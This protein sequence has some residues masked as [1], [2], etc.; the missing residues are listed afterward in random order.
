MKKKLA[1]LSLLIAFMMGLVACAPGEMLNTIIWG[2]T[3]GTTYQPVRTDSTTHAMVS[4]AYP[5]Y[6]VHGG[7]YFYVKG[8]GDGTIVFLWVCPDTARAPHANWTLSAEGEFE[9]MMY[10]GVVTSNDGAPVVVHNANR[11]SGTTATVLGFTG[12]T[13]NSGA[14]GDGGDGGDLVWAAKVGTGRQTT[15]SRG[16]SYEFVG[17]RNTKYWFQIT[18]I[19]AGTLWVDWD[20]NWYEHR[21]E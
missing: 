2:N 12:P 14:L 18:Q 15:I 19:A 16:T 20:F 13:L 11:N 5:H 10:E 1:L 6:E 4:I 21:D 7:N 17:Q 3:E 8:F 9:F